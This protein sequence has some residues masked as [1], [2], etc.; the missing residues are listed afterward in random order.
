[1]YYMNA[2][3]QLISNCWTDFDVGSHF[4]NS[5]RPRASSAPLDPEILKRTS[6]K[7]ISRLASIHNTLR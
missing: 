2:H 1:M 6:C 7:C 3:M 4:V 5:V